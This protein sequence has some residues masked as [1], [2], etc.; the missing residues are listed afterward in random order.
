MFFYICA[1]LRIY[2]TWFFL[3]FLREKTWRHQDKISLE[4]YNISILSI[5]INDYFFNFWNFK[6]ILFKYNIISNDR[7]IIS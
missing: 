5:K 4:V 3:Q 7:Q 1:Y 2:K 6:S